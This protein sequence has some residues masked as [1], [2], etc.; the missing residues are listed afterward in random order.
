MCM[1]MCMCMCMPAHYQYSHCGLHSNHGRWQLHD[2]QS[3]KEKN[4]NPNPS[5][6]S[7]NTLSCL[8]YIYTYIYN[9]YSPRQGAQAHR[10]L[11][12]PAVPIYFLE[13]SLRL[14]LPL[15]TL[16][17]IFCKSLWV[18]TIERPRGKWIKCQIW[19]R[20]A[21]KTILLYHWN[22]LSAGYPFLRARH[23][24]PYDY[25]ERKF[26]CQVPLLRTMTTLFQTYIESP[27]FVTIQS[28]II[29]PSSFKIEDKDPSPSPKAYKSTRLA[30]DA[31][32]WL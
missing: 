18:A 16:Q 6:I 23:W 29:P 11:S 21:H 8:H 31:D 27:V 32:T 7:L 15:Q 1:C 13:S 12:D 9:W 25:I 17:D 30:L 10:Q 19:R 24:W 20:V 28:S 22:T 4:W 14:S 2:V 3:W 5:T 26:E